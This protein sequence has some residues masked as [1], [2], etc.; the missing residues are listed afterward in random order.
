MSQSLPVPGWMAARVSVALG[1]RFGYVPGGVGC[2]EGV[3]GKFT[4]AIEDTVPRNVQ[5]ATQHLWI[6][7]VPR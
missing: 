1:G 6:P 5:P 4:T 2:F 7:G 3:V